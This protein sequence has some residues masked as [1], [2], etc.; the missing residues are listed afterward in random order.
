VAEEVEEVDMAEDNKGTL[1]LST[2]STLVTR[3]VD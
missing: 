2:V 1:A 3:T